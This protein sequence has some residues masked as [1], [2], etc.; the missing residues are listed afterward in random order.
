MNLCTSYSELWYLWNICSSRGAEQNIVKFLPGG[1]SFVWVTIIVMKLTM[2]SG[3]LTNHCRENLSLSS[4]SRARDD[5][6]INVS[7]LNW[8]GCGWK[9]IGAFAH[10]RERERERE[11]MCLLATQSSLRWIEALLIILLNSILEFSM[12]WNR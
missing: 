3:Q 8:L 9:G 7:D 12:L 10:V 11:H 1:F 6:L 5:G 4:E 2:Y